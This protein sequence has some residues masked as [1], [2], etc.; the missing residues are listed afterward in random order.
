MKNQMKKLYIL[1][2]FAIVSV[3]AQAKEVGVL[4]V[5][6]DQ[7]TLFKTDSK[8]PKSITRMQFGKA[9]TTIQLDDDN[10]K[11][12]A[13]EFSTSTSLSS[14]KAEHCRRNFIALNT[15]KKTV[16]GCISSK[17]PTAQGLTKLAYYLEMPFTLSKSKE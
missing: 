17:T 2:C 12:L 15:D 14:N 1:L 8:N 4:V 13:Q 6:G 9:S 7:K 5:V 16:V 3:A 10:A 11:F